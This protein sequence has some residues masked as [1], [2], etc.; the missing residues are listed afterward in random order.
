MDNFFNVQKAQSLGRSLDPSFNNIRSLVKK[1][2]FTREDF[3]RTRAN[4]VEP[5]HILVKIISALGIDRSLTPLEA[6]YRALDLFSNIS[7]SLN[8]V[9]NKTYG[10]P[11]KGEFLNNGHEFILGTM[12]RFTEKSWDQLQPVTFVYHENTNLNWL[13]GQ[14]DDSDTIAYIK[15]NIPMLARQFS[16]WSNYN[17]K[18]PEG[19][20]INVYKFL[21]RYV[22]MGS[23]W[24]YMDISLFNRFYYRIIGRDFKEDKM[25]KEFVAPDID[26]RI[27]RS[28]DKIT[29]I[30][31]RRPASLGNI[32]YHIPLLFKD[33]ALDLTNDLDVIYTRQ[34]EWFRLASILPLYHIGLEVFDLMQRPADKVSITGLQYEISSLINSSIFSKVHEHLSE[35][36]IRD[37]LDPV[38]DLTIDLS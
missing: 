33:S 1:Y 8:L 24:S 2:Q 29:R 32:L 17:S 18:L 36:I 6:Q 35:H 14:K 11:F 19:Q 28:I 15:I 7:N 27:N 9:S 34:L 22:L 25:S 31:M 23:L 13:L 16:E 5:K 38:Y 26:M 37:Y 10:K 4:A 21:W 30:I 12:E 20:Q 3:I